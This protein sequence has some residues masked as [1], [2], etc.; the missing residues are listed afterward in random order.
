[1]MTDGD[2]D[3]EMSESIH[4]LTSKSCEMMSVTN[5]GSDT[6]VLFCRMDAELTRCTEPGRRPKPDTSDTLALALPAAAAIGDA[7]DAIDLRAG[8]GTGAA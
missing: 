3:D 4:S 5:F 2:K 7:T 8:A 1:M 6:V